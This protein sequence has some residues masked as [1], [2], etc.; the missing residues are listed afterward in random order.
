MVSSYENYHREA[1]AKVPI[2]VCALAIPVSAIYWIVGYSELAPNVKHINGCSLTS[3]WRLP[4]TLTI[5]VILSVWSVKGKGLV[6]SGILSGLFVGIITNLSNYGHGACLVAFFFTASKATHFRSEKKRKL[7]TE[8]REGGQRSWKQVLCNGGM[9]TQ[10]ALVYLF[11]VGC[12]ERP[13]DFDRDCKSSSLSIGILGALACCNGDTW[14]SQIGTVLGEKEPILI[15]TGKKVPRGTNGG[16]TAIGLVVSLMGGLVV[17]ICNYIAIVCTVDP[18]ALQNA[19]P[20][21][22]I[23]VAGGFAGLLG[24]VIDSIFGA[25]LQY[26]GIDENGKIVE[27][28][29]KG[30]KHISGKQIIDDHSVNLLA[31][32]VTAWVLPNLSMIFWP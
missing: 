27:G 5:F 23:I 2:L 8:Y 1:K 17:G 26:S 4:I 10:L 13:I 11:D 15:T 24:S 21:W 6:S 31:S 25:T 29:G 9:A 18:A 14:A 3:S 30:V 20:Q 19:R 32:V 12:G 22:P 16:V 7:T 28:P